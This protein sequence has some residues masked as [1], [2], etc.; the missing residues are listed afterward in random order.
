[1]KFYKFLGTGG[2]G[3]IA[4]KGTDSGS[5]NGEFTPVL[6]TSTLALFAALY[7][8]L[9]EEGVWRGTDWMEKFPVCCWRRKHPE[10]LCCAWNSGSL[11]WSGTCCLRFYCIL[12][13]DHE[14]SWSESVLT[15]HD[16]ALRVY[17]LSRS[18]GADPSWQR[19]FMSCWIGCRKRFCC[20]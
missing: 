3:G 13:S 5:R 9:P 1:M 6:R 19:D 2:W 15:S 11:V 17:Y 18:W 10:Q 20:Q 8:S 7:D 16:V 14:T 4:Q 12:P